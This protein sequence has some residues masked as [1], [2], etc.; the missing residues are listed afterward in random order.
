MTDDAIIKE[1]VPPGTIHETDVQYGDANGIPLLLDMLRPEQPPTTPMPA[2]IWVHGGG[3]MRGERTRTPN[4]LLATR[5]YFTVTISYRFSSV[6]PFPAQL[7]DVKAAIRWIR[8]H[9]AEYG[10]DPERIGIWGHSA[11]GNLAALAA[12]TP[13]LL[14]LEGE[15]G[16]PGIDSS[17][18][19]AIPMVPP[20]DFLIDW[21]AVQRMPV[22]VEGREAMLGFIGGLWHERPEVARAA[23]PL[24]YV[25]GPAAPQLLIVGEEDDLVPYTQSLA[26]ASALRQFSANEAE[27][28]ALPGV[29]HEAGLSII[30]GIGD[31]FGLAARSVAFFERHLK[32]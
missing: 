25:H 12:M 13:N 9:A 14:E 26:Y 15:S 30:D 28:I 16:N 19:A 2:V 32:R 21:Y 18:Q 1:I 7:H 10:V 5:G 22:H 20:L 3:W 23:S 6:A 29:G 24:W 11:G 31:P 8:A 4:W 17:V 27:V